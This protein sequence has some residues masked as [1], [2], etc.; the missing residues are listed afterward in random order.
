[1][2]LKFKAG[3]DITLHFAL[4]NADGEPEALTG[5]T[6]KLKIARKLNTTDAAA[7]YLGE[8][9]AFSDAAN[10]IHDQPVANA[11][12]GAWPPGPYIYQARF[13]DS[14]GLVVSEE[15][16]D[17]IVEKNLFENEPVP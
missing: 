16:N 3:D 6:L 7:L 15:I 12:S 8:F 9:T 13:I 1:M 11:V 4:T 10:G 2:T 17:C 5:G 14:G